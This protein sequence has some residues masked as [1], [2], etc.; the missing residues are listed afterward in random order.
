MSVSKGTAQ[1]GARDGEPITKLEQALS[2]KSLSL[3]DTI[4]QQRGIRTRGKTNSAY[5]TEQIIVSQRA[6]MQFA[7]TK[8]HCRGEL[9]VRPAQHRNTTLPLTTKKHQKKVLEP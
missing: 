7:P 8:G 2:R 6:N 5:L 1:K 9:H 4:R 3:L